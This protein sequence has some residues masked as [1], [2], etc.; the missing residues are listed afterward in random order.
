MDEPDLIGDAEFFSAALG[1]LGI[2]RAHVDA[3]AADAVIPRFQA[4]RRAERGELFGSDRV[5]DAV[6][7]L[8]DVEDPWNIQCRKSPFGRE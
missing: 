1:L 4:Q 6:S 7:T 8:S 5:V 3:G 2:Q